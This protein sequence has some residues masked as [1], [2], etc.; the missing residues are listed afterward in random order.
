MSVTNEGQGRLEFE[1]TPPDVTDSTLS[2]GHK[3]TQLD[4][5]LGMLL[6]QDEVCGHADFYSE[7][8]PR[9]SVHIHRLRRRG[10]VIVK[11][12]C[13]RSEHGHIGVAWLYRLIAVPDDPAR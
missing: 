2:R 12:R 7:F 1:P 10:Y 9:F 11:S 5:V 8:I 3:P 13:T 6:D 4:R